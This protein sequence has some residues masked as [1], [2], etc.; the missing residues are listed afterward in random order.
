MGVSLFL[1]LETAKST[2]RDK[3]V[4]VFAVQLALNFAWSFI[5]FE[6][7]LVGVAFFEILMVLA[8]VAWM[9]HT[10]LPIKKGAALLQIP[11]LLWVTFASALNAAVWILN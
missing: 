8:S 9:I 3:A 5:F 7:R 10:F 1:I 11:Y 6:F 4:K 2:A